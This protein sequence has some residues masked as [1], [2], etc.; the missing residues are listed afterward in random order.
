MRIDAKRRHRIPA[1]LADQ[2][3]DLAE[4]AFDPKVLGVSCVRDFAGAKAIDVAR[5]GLA[6]LRRAKG[7]GVP[8]VNNER[9]R[10]TVD[11]R[12]ARLVKAADRAN[13]AFMTSSP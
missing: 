5:A 6:L 12:R 3:E 1:F 11:A 4:A 10:P 13:L 2:I 9:K 8:A 7:V